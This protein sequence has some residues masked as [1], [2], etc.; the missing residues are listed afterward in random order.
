MVFRSIVKKFETVLDNTTTKGMT[1][2]GH[3]GKRVIPITRN[4]SQ[5]NEEEKQKNKDLVTLEGTKR[6]KSMQEDKKI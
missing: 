1:R 5:N 3:Q 4:I 6:E 2:K